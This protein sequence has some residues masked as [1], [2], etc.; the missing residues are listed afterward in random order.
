[1]KDKFPGFFQYEISEIEEVMNHGLL[2]FDANIFLNL[3]RYS[4]STR[5]EFIGILGGL[6]ER[7]WMP[8]RAVEE[9]LENRINVIGQ[10]VSAYDATLKKVK[11]LA[12]ELQ[13]ENRHPFVLPDTLS[14]LK[15]AHEKMI[16]EL[17]ISRDKYLGYINEDPVLIELATLLSGKVGDSYDSERLDQIIKEGEVRYKEKIPPGFKDANK[18]SDDDSRK[19]LLRIY[20]DLIIWNQLIDKASEDAKDIVFVTDDKKEDWWN[21]SRGRKI[22]IQP[23]LKREFIDKT[24]RK[25]VLYQSFQFVEHASS[26]LDDNLSE[27]VVDEI[28][29]HHD[30]DPFSYY[31]DW[32][33]Q[34]ENRRFYNAEYYHLSDELLDRRKIVESVKKHMEMRLKKLREKLENTEN[35][36]APD[37]LEYLNTEIGDTIKLITE[38][39][40]Q[41]NE[42]D[43]RIMKRL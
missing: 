9:Y 26:I 6:S 10:Q 32:L 36:L 42:L 23:E 1:M 27:S 43:K 24:N 14:Q 19:G 28:R 13:T 31:D 39:S 12:D 16:R 29:E 17:E 41:I 15:N 7:V 18:L 22:G 25:I 40:L 3:Y 38:L 2:A 34:P 35:S 11:D 37:D 21:S 20:G 30:K 8:S 4:D 5:D 33:S